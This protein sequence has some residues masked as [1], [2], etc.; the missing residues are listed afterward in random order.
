VKVS[1][2]LNNGTRVPAKR[3]DGADFVMIPKCPNP[4][5]GA[6]PCKVMGD[7]RVT[8]DNGYGAHCDTYRVRAIAQCCTNDK[9]I[10]DIGVMETKVDTIFGIDED[11]AVGM[12]VRVYGG[13][14]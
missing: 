4:E 9:Q 2:V 5:C 11:I 7:G 6:A 3:P 14:R 1:I 12:R 13:E 8:H 10:V